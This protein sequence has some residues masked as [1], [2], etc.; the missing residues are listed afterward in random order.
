MRGEVTF[1]FGGEAK[2]ETLP[3]GLI[4]YR[5][6]P[7]PLPATVRVDAPTGTA[8]TPRWARAEAATA[9][10]GLLAAR[11]ILLIAPST[12][13]VDGATVT[14]DCTILPGAANETGL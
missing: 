12:R 3:A 14:L 8:L 13:R 6:P 7:M 11:P 10:A 5:T 9:P 4:L 1:R 2:R